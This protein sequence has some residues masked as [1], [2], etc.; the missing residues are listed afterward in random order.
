[1][2]GLILENSGD[3][4]CFSNPSL[5]PFEKVWIYRGMQH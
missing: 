1:M 5:F 4:A 2:E 3:R